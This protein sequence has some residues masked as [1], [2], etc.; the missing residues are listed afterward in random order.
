M[1]R[2]P[3]CPLLH[4]PFAREGAGEGIVFRN[5]QHQAFHIKGEAWVLDGAEVGD[6]RGPSCLHKFI[7]MLARLA[8]TLCY[9]SLQKGPDEL[10]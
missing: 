10:P 3:S 5:L 4:P 9:L 1:H 6:P 8:E 7:G 2:L